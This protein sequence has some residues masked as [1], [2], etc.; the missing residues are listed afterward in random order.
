MVNNTNSLISN[1]IENQKELKA[2][3]K[4]SLSVQMFVTKGS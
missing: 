1:S 4:R 3:D 2:K